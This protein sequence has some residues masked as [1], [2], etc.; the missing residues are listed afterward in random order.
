MDSSDKPSSIDLKSI[1]RPAILFCNAFGDHL[2][3]RPSIL[4]MSKIFSGNIGYIGAPGM[5]EMFFSD[6]EFSYI[7]EIPFTMG[8]RDSIS[9]IFED[10]VEASLGFFFFFFFFFLFSVV[11]LFFFFF[12]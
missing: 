4:A 5:A 7:K 1:E 2:L 10:A 6:A 12:F 3:T 11:L 9:F 8:R